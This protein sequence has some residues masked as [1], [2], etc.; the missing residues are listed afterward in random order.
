MI[1]VVVS[2]GSGVGTLPESRMPGKNPGNKRDMPE[3]NDRHQAF[4]PFGARYASASTV[5]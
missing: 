1:N 5:Q 4:S 3:C 2:R